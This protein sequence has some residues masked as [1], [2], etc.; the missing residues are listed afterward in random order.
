MLDQEKRAPLEDVSDFN[1]GRMI[2][3]RDC[4]KFGY[5]LPRIWLSHW[6]S[7]MRH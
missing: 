2:A 1:R 4:G 7:V 6:T 3:Y 5:R